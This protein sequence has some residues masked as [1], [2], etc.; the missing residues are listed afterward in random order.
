[1]KVFVVLVVLTLMATSGADD[2]ES[3]F[4]TMVLSEISA[5]KS[6][7][8]ELEHELKAKDHENLIL[9]QHLQHSKRYF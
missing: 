2:T 9:N 8:N 6:K 7:V 3:S 1:M 4:Q 5:L